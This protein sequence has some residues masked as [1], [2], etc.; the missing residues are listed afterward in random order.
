MGQE[1]V[2]EGLQQVIENAFVKTVNGETS[3]W[4]GVGES[5]KYGGLLGGIVGMPH[6]AISSLTARKAYREKNAEIEQQA[7]AYVKN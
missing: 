5:M 2:T 4:E 3:L 1:A 7:R 6:S